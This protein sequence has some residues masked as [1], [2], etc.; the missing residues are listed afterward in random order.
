ME[1]M[2]RR[3]IKYLGSYNA[4]MGRVDDLRARRERLE[5][6]LGYTGIVIDGMPKSGT[7]TDGM[8]KVVKVIDRVA[9]I[10]KEL[11]RQEREAADYAIDI[12]GVL[13]LLP[14]GSDDRRALELRFIDRKTTEEI[15][16][17]MAIGVAT[18]WRIYERAIKDL[19]AKPEVKAILA[20]TED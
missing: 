4:A 9:E 1:K 5:A 2:R 3:L 16:D 12:I 19:A 20:E 18:Y 10:S 15:A 8:N 17:K 6:T 13:S 11:Q 14:D 7:V